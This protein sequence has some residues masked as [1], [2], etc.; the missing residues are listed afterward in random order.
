MIS[1]HVDELSVMT[2]LSQYP[3]VVVK[4]DAPIS[5]RNSE[6][7]PLKKIME[8][9][10]QIVDASLVESEIPVPID[11]TKVKIYGPGITGNGV[12]IGKPAM[13]SIDCTGVSLVS[14][15]L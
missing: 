3:K 5:N 14:F 2:Y 8:Q 6:T 10:F 1:M 9:E 7:S 11:G 13:V 4:P 15:I 12:E